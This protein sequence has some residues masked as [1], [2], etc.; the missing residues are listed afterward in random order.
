MDRTAIYYR[1]E[2]TPDTLPTHWGYL[3]DCWQEGF[4]VFASFAGA[5]SAG[6]LGRDTDGDY[7]GYTHLMQIEA[8]EDFVVD[9]AGEYFAIEP[10]GVVA[11][12]SVALD[13]VRQA[14]EGIEEV[15]FESLELEIFKNATEIEPRYEDRR[16]D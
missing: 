13:S 9:G 11:V 6:V 12:R 8:D 1:L 4:Q 5:V 15:E 2:R 10:G 14:L 3:D 16:Q 7:S